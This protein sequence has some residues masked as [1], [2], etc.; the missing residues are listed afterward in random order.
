MATMHLCPGNDIHYLTVD[1]WMHSIG[2]ADPVTRGIEITVKYLGFNIDVSQTHLTL[3]A[4]P[5]MYE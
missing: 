1:T 2:Y 3:S 5:S 4:L